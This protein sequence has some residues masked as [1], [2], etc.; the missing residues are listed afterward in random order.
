MKQKNNPRT[1]YPA[2]L[3]TKHEKYAHVYVFIHY[4]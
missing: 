3:K 2:K 1:L 4:V